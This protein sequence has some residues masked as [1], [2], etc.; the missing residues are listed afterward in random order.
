MR[1]ERT[2]DRV[3]FRTVMHSPASEGGFEASCPVSLIT[4]KTTPNGE[5]FK[6]IFYTEEIAVIITALVKEGLIADSG[7]NWH[8]I[9]ARRYQRLVD[10]GWLPPERAEQLQAQLRLAQR[11]TPDR[12]SPA[13]DASNTQRRPKIL[14]PSGQ[15]LPKMPLPL[16][17]RRSQP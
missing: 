15:L 17:L 4:E 12:P 5:V 1:I 6:T 11:E 16:H 7:G 8:E 9:N 3:H 2:K 14:K 13:G 10:R